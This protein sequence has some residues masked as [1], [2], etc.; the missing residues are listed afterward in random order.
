[1]N[2]LALF[3]GGGGSVLAGTILGWRTRCAVELDAGARNIMLDRQRDDFG[4][5]Q[6]LCDC[7]DGATV[8]LCGVLVL[9]FT[10][11]PVGLGEGFRDLAHRASAER[12]SQAILQQHIE[13]PS[14]TQRRPRAFQQ[15]RSTAHRLHATG[16]DDVR[17]S[18][19]NRL[20]RQHDRLQAGPA[21]FV[22]RQRRD[23]RRQTRSQRR[24]PS[25]CLSDSGS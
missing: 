1:M 7:G 9:I 15:I 23:G 6:T 16:H 22:D 8:T 24:L 18:G 4:I 21:D 11:Q 25:G 17:I 19:A 13:Q 3:A 10:S 14:L 5:E 20:R 2:E 12:T